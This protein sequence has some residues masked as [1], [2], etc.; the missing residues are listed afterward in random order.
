MVI[1]AIFCATLPQVSMEF[2][3]LVQQAEIAWLK[4]RFSDTDGVSM[5]E[6]RTFAVALRGWVAPAFTATASH[7]PGLPKIT[8]D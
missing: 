1:F 5:A 6:V 3:A 4:H 7:L 8:L 2:H